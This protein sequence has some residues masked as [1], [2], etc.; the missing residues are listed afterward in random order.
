MKTY[1]LRTTLILA[2]AAGTACASFTVSDSAIIE[3]TAFALSLDKSAFTISDRNNDDLR[4]SYSVKT[5]TGKKYSCYVGGSMSVLG[6]QATDAICNEV[7]NP[8]S[9]KTGTPSPSCNALL[10][11]AGR[12]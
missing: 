5:N 3:R 4:A 1:L 9:S 6:T 8:T 2:A 12:C 10:K 11:A 7:G